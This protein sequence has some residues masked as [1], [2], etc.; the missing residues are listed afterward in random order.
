MEYGL[1]VNDEVDERYH[2][3]RSTAAACRFLKESFEIY[4]SWTMAAASYNMGR[5]G[6][7]RQVERQKENNYYDLLL[8]EET[9]RYV[10][11]LI[12]LKL[13]LTDP[14]NYG[15]HVQEGDLFHM[16]PCH[17]VTIE[18]PVQDFAEFAREQGTNYKMLKMFNP[19][20][21]DN[22][23]TNIKGKTYHINIPQ[24]GYRETSNQD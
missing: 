23:L 1:E 2:L 4:D 5:K 7:T 6:L 12:A 22:K 21:R 18:G 13:I 14:D 19:W 3:E 16:I 20:L 9:G 10:Y 24:D 15:F 8:G 17:R 11:R